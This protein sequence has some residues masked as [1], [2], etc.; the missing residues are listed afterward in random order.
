MHGCP[1]RSFT[2]CIKSLDYFQ[3]VTQRLPSLISQTVQ[4]LMLSKSAKRTTFYYITVILKYCWDKTIA[5]SG[6][7]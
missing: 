4:R 7:M 5:R 1:D 3:Y 6:D 2:P